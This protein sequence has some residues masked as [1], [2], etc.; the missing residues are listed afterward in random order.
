MTAAHEM[1]GSAHETIRR[2]QADLVDTQAR[3]LAGLIFK[4]RYAATHYRTEYD[5]AVMTSIVDDL[6]AMAD[7]PEGLAEA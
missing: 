5:G 2:V 4:A 6:L 1:E 7:D 3:T